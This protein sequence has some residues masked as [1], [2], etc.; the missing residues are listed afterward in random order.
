MK[1][2]IYLLTFLIAITLTICAC[3]EKTLNSNV[4]SE[5]NHMA[6]Q[7]ENTNNLALAKQPFTNNQGQ[8]TNDPMLAEMAKE[9]E[10]NFSQVDPSKLA[11]N[12]APYQTPPAAH[13]DPVTNA[14]K[15]NPFGNSFGGQQNTNNGSAPFSPS[16]GSGFGNNTANDNGMPF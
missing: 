2:I 15:A 1:K 12:N 3:D 4:D 7:I 10:T 5:K 14:P 11:N 13:I 16:F 6:N 8:T 9:Q